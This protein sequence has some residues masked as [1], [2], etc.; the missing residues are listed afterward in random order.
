[1]A[2]PLATSGVRTCAR[3]ND[4]VGVGLFAAYK[5]DSSKCDHFHRGEACEKA[6]TVKY[7]G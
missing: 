4:A 6:V 3:Q 7:A 5:L 1:M 2:E